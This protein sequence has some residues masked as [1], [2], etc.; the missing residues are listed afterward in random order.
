MACETVL[1]QFL[2][3][4]ACY[5]LWRLISI[6]KI[7]NILTAIMTATYIITLY[8]GIDI[9][10]TDI[11]RG[12]LVD[13]VHISL[14]TFFLKMIIYYD[15]NG[16]KLQLYFLDLFIC[17]REFTLLFTNKNTTKYKQSTYQKMAAFS[18][19]TIFIQVILWLPGI[20][21]W[22]STHC[23]FDGYAYTENWTGILVTS[24]VVIAGTCINLILFEKLKCSIWITIIIS[25]MTFINVTIALSMFTIVYSIISNDRNRGY[26]V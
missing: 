16:G 7:V 19:L 11:F 18:Y 12:W 15:E 22:M 26:S 21:K 25:L 4:L 1:I 3:P 8:K 17:P 20:V 10:S 23:Y 14:F 2:F 5:I 13:W 24:N 9:V 6:T